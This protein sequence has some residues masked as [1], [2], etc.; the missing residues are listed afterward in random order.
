MSESSEMLLDELASIKNFLDAAMAEMRTGS[1]PDI[2]GLE[3]RVSEVCQKVQSA[4]DDA[5]KKCLPE[6]SLLLQ[7]LDECERS[8]REWHAAAMKIGKN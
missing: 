8:M 4:D 5:Q 1:L 6:L 3:Q 2:T 7:S